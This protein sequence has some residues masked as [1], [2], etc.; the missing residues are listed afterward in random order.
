MSPVAVVPS[1]FNTN[2]LPFPLSHVR[3]DPSV[4]ID[5]V[6]LWSG[7]SGF[8]LV[9]TFIVFINVGEFVLIVG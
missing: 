4:A 5:A 2:P 1:L 7:G 9:E 3:R 8:L 6:T